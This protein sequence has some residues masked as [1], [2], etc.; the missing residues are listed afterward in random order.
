VTFNNAQTIA[1][2]LLFSLASTVLGADVV[3]VWGGARSTIILKSDGTVWT[4]GANFNGKLGLGETNDQRA[5]TPVEVHGPGNFSYLNSVTAVMGGEIHNVAL[6]VDGTVWCW[7]W[8]AFGQLGNGTT[9]DSWVPVQAGLT[10]MPP[11]TNVVK[12]FDRSRQRFHRLAK[13]RARNA[14]DDCDF[15]A[16]NQRRIVFP[17]EILIAAHLWL[18]R[19]RLRVDD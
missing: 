9:N 8:N 5:L 10:A 14:T 6:K 16:A 17:P 3:S 13:Q 1:T 7:G 18:N 2:L 19:G 4:W 11:L 12:I 15:G